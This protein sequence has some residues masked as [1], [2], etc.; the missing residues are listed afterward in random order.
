MGIR[1]SWGW[2]WDWEKAKDARRRQMPAINEVRIRAVIPFSLSLISS[3]GRM[4]PGTRKTSELHGNR[5][6]RRFD[7][8]TDQD[9]RDV[10]SLQILLILKAAIKSEENFRT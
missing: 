7:L 1:L 10:S 9:D 4:E 2:D 5:S 6:V 3:P 8:D